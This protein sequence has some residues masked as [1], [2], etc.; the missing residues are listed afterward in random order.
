MR[1]SRL[2]R[3]LCFLSQTQ[4]GPSNHRQPFVPPKA[5]TLCRRRTPGNVPCESPPHHAIAAISIDSMAITSSSCN[6]VESQ[7]PFFCCMFI[8]NCSVVPNRRPMRRHLSEYAIGFPAE[9][10]DRSREPHCPHI[11]ASEALYE[12]YRREGSCSAPSRTA[13]S[14]R[15]RRTPLSSPT[16]FAIT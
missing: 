15:H 1:P 4:P 5:V 9:G 8:Q 7:M 3:I 14:C 16:S 6:A 11:P 2:I 13:L 12:Q 10:E